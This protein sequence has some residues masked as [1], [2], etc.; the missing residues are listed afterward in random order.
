[1]S[2]RSRLLR[3]KYHQFRINKNRLR[4]NLFGD[5]N[6]KKF[7]IISDARTGSTLLLNL[8]GFHPS[9][10]TEG[11]RFKNING[12]NQEEI[13]ND[14]FRKRQKK[15]RYV[16][17][18][19]FYFHAIE[20]DR[21]VWDYLKENKSITVIHLIRDN[22]LRS[23]VSKKIGLKTR[24]WTENIHSKDIIPIEEKKVSLNVEECR[25]YFEEMTAYQERIN[26]MFKDHPLIHLSYEDLA[27][28]T[29]EVVDDLYKRLGVKTYRKNSQLK[30]QNP[31]SI[32][33]L[34]LNYEELKNEFK[35]SRWEAFFE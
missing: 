20:G 7:V 22:I 32:Q 33:E 3:D 13:W 23:L 30:K 14:I 5:R 4:D 9:I 34:V 35:G 15:L 31:E 2:L 10:E 17:F 21:W 11:E 25:N 6:Y 24:R 29:R 12:Q 19:L 26:K 16:G 27:G 8:L 1:M 18:K 28:N